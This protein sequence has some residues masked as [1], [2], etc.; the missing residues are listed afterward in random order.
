MMVEKTLCIIKPNAVV[1]NNIGNIILR[2]ESEGLRIAAAKFTHLSKEKAEGF[3]IEHKGKPFFGSLVNFM[4]SG[5]VL[6]LVLE[7]EEAIKRNRDIM[8][9]TNPA[10]AQPGTLRKMYA[11]SLEQNAVHGSDSQVSAKREVAYFFDENEVFTRF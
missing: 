5:P 11:R 1:D 3:Y 7:G 6:L 4:T 10:E 2:Y 8:G 9:S